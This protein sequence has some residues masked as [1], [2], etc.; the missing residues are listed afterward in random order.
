MNPLSIVQEYME[1]TSATVTPDMEV[2][3]AVLLLLKLRI[4]A[5]PVVEEGGQLAGILTQRD[6]LEAFMDE[7]YYDE[8][9]AL[10]RDLMSTDVV[11]IRP[12]ASVFEAA[13]LFSRHSFHLLP[14]IAEEALVGQISRTDVIRAILQTHKAGSCG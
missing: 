9:T 4:S 14:V 2:G 8:P 13:E 12:D 11:T 3:E 1:R 5:V 10:V 7:E 6:C